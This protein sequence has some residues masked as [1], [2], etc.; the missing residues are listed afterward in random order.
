MTPEWARYLGKAVRTNGLRRVGRKI[1]SDAHRY[2]LSNWWFAYPEKAAR[3]WS[4]GIRS[5]GARR[6]VKLSHDSWKF[7]RNWRRGH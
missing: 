3:R 7:N 2:D 5:H 1:S 4:I 6:W